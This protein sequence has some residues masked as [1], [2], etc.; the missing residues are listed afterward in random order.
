[1]HRN[2][3]GKIPH[4]PASSKIGHRCQKEPWH[5]SAQ[6]AD[7]RM[8]KEASS[9]CNNVISRFRN[10][11]QKIRSLPKIFA[12]WLQFLP[13]RILPSFIQLFIPLRRESFGFV[14]NMFKRGLQKEK[15]QDS[16]F[17]KPAQ[18]SYK[19]II[20]VSERFVFKYPQPV[21]SGSED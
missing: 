10:R 14:I 7:P 17:S 13:G 9:A 16:E 1:M 6:C 3:S 20:I 19:M 4:S 15:R 2:Q 12:T 18:F 11:V 21:S 5:T 8:D